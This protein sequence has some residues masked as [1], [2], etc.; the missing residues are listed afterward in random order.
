MH[1]G[2]VLPDPDV[3][4]HG[5][6]GIELDDALEEGPRLALLIEDDPILGAPPELQ[7]HARGGDSPDV[8]RRT[9]LEVR[10]RPRRRRASDL[11]TGERLQASADRPLPRLIADVVARNA[12]KASVL[13]RQVGH[14]VERGR[15]REQMRMACE[16]EQSLLAAHAPA[17]RVDAAL[18]D[19]HP[20]KGSVDDRRHLGQVVDLSGRSPRVTRKA[21][22]LTLRAEHG[23]RALRRQSAPKRRVRERA[24]TTP[25]RRDD[26]GNRG[27]VRRPV[28]GRQQ[29]IRLAPRSVVGA[30][31]DRRDPH[32]PFRRRGSG[33]QRRRRDE[34]RDDCR[35]ESEREAHGSQADKVMGSRSAPHE[36][37]ARSGRSSRT[38]LKDR[39]SPLWGRTDGMPGRRR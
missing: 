11:L 2:R 33:R 32:A 9:A 38:A 4:G 36:Q 13:E 18:V 1:L 28:P 5:R 29:Q 30:V 25:V 16:Q 19:V 15:S 7:R 22:A 8:G 6:I 31:L 17:E 26:E 39:S 37:R 14:R 24:D 34:R 12:Q 27:I 10:E 20:R 3:G 35:D 21:A 23:K